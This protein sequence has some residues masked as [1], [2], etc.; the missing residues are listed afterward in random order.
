MLEIGP[1]AG[2]LTERLVATGARVTAVEV[3]PHMGELLR[4]NLGE[5]ENL[6]VIGA[7]ILKVN[8]TELLGT[9]DQGWAV[10]GNLPYHVTT[11]VLFAMLEHRTR[12]TRMVFTVQQEV[13]DR[14]IAKPGSDDYSALTVALAHA[15]K[16]EK[17]FRIGAGAFHPKPKVDSAVIRFTPA[18]NEYSPAFDKALRDVVRS[19]FGQRRKTLLNAL[20][21]I[22]GSRE[23]AQ[24]RL[25]EAAIDGNRRGETLTLEEFRKIAGVFAAT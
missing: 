23:I 11:P 14:M 5:P 19:S 15:G 8:L 12:V 17:L 2:F 6:M 4:R 16:T 9:S 18:R 10:A 21:P 24:N 25:T 13:A 3:D 20:A 1:G 7:D 22:A